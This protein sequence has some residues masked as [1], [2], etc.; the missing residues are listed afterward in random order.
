MCDF[1]SHWAGLAVKSSRALPVTFAIPIILFEVL[2]KPREVDGIILSLERWVKVNIILKY[3]FLCYRN[4]FGWK[5]GPLE[6][7]SS[8]KNLRLYKWNCF[9]LYGFEWL[10][11][12]LPMFPSVWPLLVKCHVAVCLTFIAQLPSHSHFRKIYCLSAFTLNVSKAEWS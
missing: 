9:L 5:T 8:E 12:D 2:M 10:H 1:G 4:K 11:P 6:I 3:P 7:W